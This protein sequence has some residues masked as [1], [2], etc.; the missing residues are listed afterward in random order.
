MKKLTA[1]EFQSL[2]KEE[3]DKNYMNLADGEMARWRLLYDIPVPISTGKSF[4]MTEEEK[5]EATRVLNE[6]IE[7][8]K[9][10]MKEY[11]QKHNKDKE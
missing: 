3:K 2:S 6:F 9:K 8:D 1:E 10:R 5:Q 4:E 11:M 7:R